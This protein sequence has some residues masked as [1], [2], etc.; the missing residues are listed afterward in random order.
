MAASLP[1]QRASGQALA[2]ADLFKA[3]CG[4]CHELPDPEETPRERGEWQ[5]L[6]R[7]MIERGATLD[8]REAKSV[9]DYLD[10][11]NK[12]ARSI[13]WSR[14]P[15]ASHRLAVASLTALGENWVDIVAGGDARI[16][17]KLTAQPSGKLLQPNRTGTGREIPLLIDN[18]GLIT[19]GLISS[20][21]QLLSAAGTGGGGIVFGFKD[22]QNF[23]GARLGGRDIILYEVKNG[24]RALLGRVRFA[25][26]EKQWRTLSVALTG[27]LVK[28]S[29]DGKEL[30][31]LTQQLKDYKGGLA[32]MQVQGGGAAGFDSWSVEVR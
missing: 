22:A 11:F 17:W 23:Y 26:P 10:S 28:V 16:P 6:V 3:N 14:E 15:A 20:R 31:A 2:G 4:G 13:R 24:Q 12:T 30:T 19:N 21:I 1:A 8:A 5:R 32:G 7:Q 29:L 9:V 27:E 25:T 18:S